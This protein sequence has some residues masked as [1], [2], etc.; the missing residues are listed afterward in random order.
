MR[1]NDCCF[2]FLPVLIIQNIFEK[3][4]KKR[5]NKKL[6]QRKESKTE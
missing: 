6:R 1:Q 3:N 4:V 5:L 2:Y